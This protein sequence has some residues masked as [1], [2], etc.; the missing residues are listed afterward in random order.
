MDTNKLFSFSRIAMVMKREVM[1]NWKMNLY[2]LAGVYAAFASPMLLNMLAV[3]LDMDAQMAFQQYCTRMGR[4]F[5][6]ITVFL[7]IIFVT[8]ILENMKTKEQRTAFLMLPATMIEKFVARFL[9]VTVGMAIA[10]VVSALLAEVTRYLVLPLY[11]LPD[12]FY[13]PVLCGMLS[14]EFNP[15]NIVGR[16]WMP[17]W[18]GAAFM[19]WGHSLYLL[20]GS[21]WYK[22]PFLKMTAVLFL[23]SMS[24]SFLM[25][26]AVLWIGHE[27]IH[28]FVKWLEEHLQWMTEEYFFAM[29]MIFFNSLTL[30]NWWLSYRLF[31]RSQ[32]IK[33]KFR[34]L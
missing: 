23:V 31:A 30:F 26:Q 24:A 13:Q 32:V 5:I 22:S 14:G 3:D 18:M 25:V 2:R 10:I 27:N 1:E 12:T 21:L 8:T 20:G 11:H 17:I 6:L 28:I 34:L 16:E 7:S 4:S 19:L 33:P 29:W 9:M 15:F